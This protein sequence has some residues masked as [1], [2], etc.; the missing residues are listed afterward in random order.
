M[1]RK[2]SFKPFGILS[3][4]TVFSHLLV[5][6]SNF[7]VSVNV[8]FSTSL[9]DGLSLSRKI[10]F[11]SIFSTFMHGTLAC[12]SSF[13]CQIQIFIPQPVKGHFKLLYCCLLTVTIQFFQNHQPSI[14]VYVHFWMTDFILLI[15]LYEWKMKTNINCQISLKSMVYL[16]LIK[17]EQKWNPLGMSKIVS[18]K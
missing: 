18:L 17:V 7:F 1:G 13:L 5:Q 2:M 14:S 4:H 9:R 11:T 15:T 12:L 8:F 6:I 16:S 10:Y 3:W